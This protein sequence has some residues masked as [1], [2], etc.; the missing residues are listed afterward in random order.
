[1][2]YLMMMKQILL[3]SMLMLANAGIS[4]T[5][6]TIQ[7]ENSAYEGYSIVH[8][9]IYDTTY[10]IDNCGDV[11]NRW[12]SEYENSTFAEITKNGTL[13]RSSVD[14]NATAFFQGGAAGI[15]Q[16]LTWDGNVIWEH[17][18]SN[19][20]LRLHHDVEILPNG[21]ILVIVWELK[22][23]QECYAAGRTPGTLTENEMWFSVIYEL[24]PVYPSGANIVWEWHAW[25][26]LIQDENDLSQNYGNVQENFRRIDINKGNPFN[27][28]NWDHINSVDY[29][30]EL[31]HILLSVPMFNEIWMIDHST[32]SAE[33][34]D[35]VGGNRGRGGDLLWRWGNPQSYDQGNWAD[36]QLFFQHDCQWVE[37]GTR[38]NDHI[39]VFS[40]R[41]S[42]NGILGSKVKIIEASFDSV[43]NSYPMMNG[44][45][46]PEAPEYVYELVD[47]LV[48]PRLSGAQ[49]LPNDNIL[50]SAGYHGH[51][52]EIDSNDNVV[53]QYKVPINGAGVHSTQGN[54]VTTTK[55]IFLMKRYQPNY[56]GFDG[57]DLTPGAPIELN[58]LSCTSSVGFEETVE[59]N[60]YQIYPNP[61]SDYFELN[62]LNP[63]FKILVC[64]ELGRQLYIFDTNN[65]LLKVDC[66][67][68]PSGIYLIK[69]QSKV[70]RVII[71]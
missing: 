70:K 12:A 32:T 34:A 58:P 20:L 51:V 40:N 30:E 48:S 52:V 50:V 31:D 22:T 45:F 44:K 5:V 7:Y 8:P 59:G 53:W 41:D 49:V 55:N 66:S 9:L 67:R 33:A 35:S 39:S 1:M 43:S 18:M 21:N 42:I 61:S 14:P 57:L 69:H 6:G 62:G 63:D 3:T 25:N 64:D 16:E 10:L 54:P 27:I 68:W 46:L 15:L 4:Q 38:F 65:S 2:N 37:E 17:T 71:D 29:N 24:E 13:L 28:A 11:I 56:I 19:N 23:L 60:D 36:Q 26:H 47:T